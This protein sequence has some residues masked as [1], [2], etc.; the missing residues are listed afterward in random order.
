MKQR[1]PAGVRWEIKFKILGATRL[2]RALKTRQFGI[3]L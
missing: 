1:V 3:Y 2:F